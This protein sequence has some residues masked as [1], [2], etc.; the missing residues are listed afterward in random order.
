MVEVTWSMRLWGYRATLSDADPGVNSLAKFMVVVEIHE[1]S[2]FVSQEEFNAVYTRG[3]RLLE[4]RKCNRIVVA[5]TVD[6]MILTYGSHS[7]NLGRKCPHPAPDEGDI[8]ARRDVGPRA[9]VLHGTP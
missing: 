5:G 9:P 3:V 6:L 8:G 7:L 1:A 4:A 2:H